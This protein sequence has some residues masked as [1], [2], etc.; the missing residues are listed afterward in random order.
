MNKNI[1]LIS[2]VILGGMFLTG[3]VLAATTISLSPASVS[4]TQGES[5]NLVIAVNPQGVKNYT[6]KVELEY[7]T[8]LLEVKSF[9]FSNGW[10]AL[11]QTGYDLIDNT[12]GLLIKTA[13]YPGG[14][15]TSA[16]FGTVSFSAKKSGSGVIKLTSNSMALDA[17]NEN[18]LSS[19]LAQV[20][21]SIA[22]P[23]P[24][25]PGPTYPD[26]G[27]EEIKEIDEIDEIDE[28]D[29]IEEDEITED[30]ED[31]I[32]EEEEPAEEP[33]FLAAI[34]NVITFGTG[35]AFIGVIA[36]IIALLIL[37]FIVRGIRL[38]KSK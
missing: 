22:A 31:I 33:S 4:V 13:G 11:S 27:T 3:S 2:L 38:R 6:V 35:N 16:T 36:S 34:G 9:S 14:I 29:E 30:E 19:P 7:P 15:P 25:A 10:M 17:E 28:P 26:E 37:F 23:A 12:N 20:T 18:V 24:I 8:D 21:V 5:F 1:L 32:A